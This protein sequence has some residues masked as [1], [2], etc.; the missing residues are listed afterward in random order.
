MTGTRMGV[1]LATSFEVISF[2]MPEL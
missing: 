1:K 2:E